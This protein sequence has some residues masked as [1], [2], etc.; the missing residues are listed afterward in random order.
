MSISV[1]TQQLVIKHNKIQQHINL[2]IITKDKYKQFLLGM[3]TWKVSN[4]TF[5]IQLQPEPMRQNTPISM[6]DNWNILLV[7]LVHNKCQLV[8]IHNNWSSNTIKCNILTWLSLLRINTN[9]SWLKLTPGRYLTTQLTSKYSRNQCVKIH[10]Y[11][12][13]IFGILY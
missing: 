1:N 5:Y 11:P 12:R 6:G 8:P 9:S 4:D 13:V 2:V 10:Q 3:H 7:Y